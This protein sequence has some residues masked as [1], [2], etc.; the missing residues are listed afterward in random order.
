MDAL[1]AESEVSESDNNEDVYTDQARGMFAAAFL[2]DA[3]GA[4]HEFYKW[5][6][7]TKYTGKL[8]IQPYRQKDARFAKEGE[9]EVY[10][11]IGSVTDEASA[12]HS[13]RYLNI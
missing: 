5:N 7:D 8:E 13:A 6:R 10:K 1:S 12:L 3:L 11:P 4:P 2:G 9:R